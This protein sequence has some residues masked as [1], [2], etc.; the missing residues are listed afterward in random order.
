MVLFS[1]TFPGNVNFDQPLEISKLI[2]LMTSNP[3]KIGYM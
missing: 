2:Y 3:G 1:K